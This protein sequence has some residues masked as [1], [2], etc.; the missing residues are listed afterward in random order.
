MVKIKEVIL[1]RKIIAIVVLLLIISVVFI[2]CK[3]E[4][5]QEQ[6]LQ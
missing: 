4:S 3:S 1:M 5:K 2:G 6:E